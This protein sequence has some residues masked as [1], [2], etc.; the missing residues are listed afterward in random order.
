MR[1][2]ARR[3]GMIAAV[4]AG[5][6]ALG[7][8]GAVGLTAFLQEGASDE[9]LIDRLVALE[10][11]LPVLPPVE[12]LIDPEETWAELSGD[13]TGARV[14]LDT[15]ADEARSLFVTAEESGGPVAE[16][17]ADAARAMLVLRAGYTHL[18]EWE[19]HDLAFPLDATDDDDVA[20]GADELYGEAEVGLSL[21]LDARE[22]S[23]TAYALLR[24]SEAADGD[25]RAVLEARHRAE[26]EFDRSTKPDV[27]RALSY[28]TT[29][30][31]VTVSRFVTSA[32]GTESRA[33]VMRVVCIDRDA[34]TTAEVPAADEAA[35]AS[36]VTE[37]ADD[38]PAVDNGNEVRLIEP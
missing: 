25:E 33:K 35:L 34:Y 28:D 10:Q 9:E 37:A 36:L 22:R 3:M 16:A 23:L 30:V 5:V 2:I 11:Q 7:A 1:T 12:V 14:A 13:F 21:V 4:V 20:A 29:Q 27:H 38:C 31:L 19:T 26:V 17:V 6:V 24:D 15:V 8:V 32:P 18:A